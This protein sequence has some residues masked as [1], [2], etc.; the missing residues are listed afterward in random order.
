MSLKKRHKIIDN[1]HI[2]CKHCEKEMV[3]RN[4]VTNCRRT[5]CS[6]SC[7]SKFRLGKRKVALDERIC[8]NELCKKKFTIDRWRPNKFCSLDCNVKNLRKFNPMKGSSMKEI[9]IKKYGEK[10]GNEKIKQMNA[11]I[12]N[13]ISVRL[14]KM[15]PEDL[16]KRMSSAMSSEKNKLPLLE[17]W[18]IK[19]GKEVADLKMIEHSKKLSAKRRPQTLES[20]AKMKISKIKRVEQKIKAK[21]TPTYNPNA[22]FF[23]DNYAKENNYSFQHAENGGEFFVTDIGCFL[24]GYDEERNTVIEYNERYHFDTIGV[25]LKKHL[26]RE[27]LIINKLKCDLIRVN[28]FR[29]NEIKVEVLK[30]ADPASFK[31]NEYLTDGD[32]K[33]KNMTLKVLDSK[34]TKNRVTM[35]MS[36]TLKYN[37]IGDQVSVE[38]NDGKII[39]KKP[40]ES[41]KSNRKINNRRMFSFSQKGAKEY[42]GTW[43][44]SFLDG[45]FCCYEKVEE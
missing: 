1:V 30:Y 31:L 20:I 32:L 38:I 28:E 14:S 35:F 41:D 13:N 25:L 8:K 10:E 6:I 11:K 5:F 44:V 18:T 19:Y 39:L 43:R 16:K 42:I 29:K 33:Y 2:K 17:Q 37:I 23:I 27:A 12:S 36:R 40:T 3:F 15:S 21:I 9:F 24:D 26:M 34:R 4:T 7:R 45:L 22:C